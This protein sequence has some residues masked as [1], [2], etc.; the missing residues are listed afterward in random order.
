MDNESRSI[1][2]RVGTFS[3]ESE[4]ETSASQIGSYPSA[5]ILLLS[6][7][8]NIGAPE[9]L[10]IAQVAADAG[11]RVYTVGIGSPEGAV[12]EIDGFQILSQLNERTLQEISSVTN[13]AYY[14]ADNSADLEDIYQNVDLQLTIDGEKMEITALIAGLGMLFLLTG[15][16]LSM[17]WFGRIP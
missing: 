12:V 16:A 14:H 3:E 15:G 11:V 1:P 2:K 5:V 9:P 8:E 17:L 6:D 13:G 10:K 4:T 7:G